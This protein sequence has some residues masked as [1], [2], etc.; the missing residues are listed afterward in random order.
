MFI[1]PVFIYFM[2]IYK[3]TFKCKIFTTQITLY[4]FSPVCVLRCL[5]RELLCENI[6]SHWSHLYGFSLLYILWLFTKVTLRVIIFSHWS[7]TNGFSPVCN[8]LWL[9]KLLLNVKYWPLRSHLN[10]F[11]PVCVFFQFSMPCHNEYRFLTIMH[12]HM[13]WKTSPLTVNILALFFVK[14]CIIRS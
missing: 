1:L 13:L 8:A 4:G 14:Q 5:S 12:L 10:G 11:S 2:L 6:A 9:I 7:H 3:I